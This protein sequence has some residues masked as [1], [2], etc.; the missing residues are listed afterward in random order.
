MHVGVMTKLVARY[1]NEESMSSLATIKTSI[2]QG[3]DDPC[4]S[5]ELWERLLSQGQTDTVNLT[6]AW[7]KT[8]WEFF[9]K[10]D[11]L[12][13]ALK[14]GNDL[15]G[16]APWFAAD[17]MIIN[18]CPEDWLD[19][20]GDFSD[21]DL[22]ETLLIAARDRVSYFSGFR[23]Y[24][25]PDCSNTSEQIRIAA[26]RLGLDCYE[27]AELPS[28]VLDIQKDP[29]RARQC[30]R[31][32]SLRR[33]GRFFEMHG[34]YEVHCSRSAEEILPW[35]DEFFD[36]HVSR[37]SITPHPSMFSQPLQREYYRCL[38]QRIGPL[39][40]LRFTRLRWQGRNIA[41]HFGF[42][43]RGRY[44]WGIPTFAMDLAK[45]SPGEVLLQQVLLDAIEEGADT[46]DFGP[47]EEV[48][49]YR[50]ANRVVKLRTWGL[51]PQRQ[52]GF[53]A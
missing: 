53:V 24:F 12:L 8:W 30:T 32:E 11:L 46:F 21:P 42:S 3:F 13:V 16:I 15:I 41:F 17:G 27:E 29:E 39:G 28:P 35:L 14:R 52:Q 19:L 43:Y 37:R 18:L 38:T 33:H 50:F 26:E 2:L 45:R 31:K 6:W 36:Q 1:R 25:I 48:Y 44:L 40:W 51:Y 49:K 47:G 23:L 10:G 9:G 4:L 22:I 7:Q 5:P 20:V 34:G